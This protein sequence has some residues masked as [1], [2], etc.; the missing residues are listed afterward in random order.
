MPWKETDVMQE[1]IAFVVEA[2]GGT[3]SISALCRRYGISRKTGYKWLKRYREVKTLSE[4]SEASRRPHTS[5][6]KTPDW[7]EERVE[8]LR[9]LE[10]WG[11]RKI[12]RCLASEGVHLA[13]STVDRILERR[14]LIPSSSRHKPAVKRFEREAPNEMSQM[15]FK[16]WYP[17]RR[18]GQ[19]HPLS[20]LD[21]HSR[22]LQGL[23]ALPGQKTEPVKKCLISSWNLYGVPQSI[24]CDHGSP[25]WATSNGHGLTKL[26]VFLIR[27]GINILHG[28][29]G[30]PQ[31]QGKIER[32]HRTLDQSIRHRGAPRTL[33]EFQTAFDEFRER[34]NDLRPHEALGDDPP[35][36][37]YQPSL[38]AYE[39]NPREWEYPE[40]AK[41]LRVRDHG[42]VS[43]RSR[44]WFVCHALA[45]RR[46]R[47]DPFDSK[48]LVS[49]RHM[50]IREIDLETG[51]TTA[52]V[53]P[54]KWKYVLPMSPGQPVT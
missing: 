25:W 19:C 44:D 18:K 27:Q 31:T 24:L 49:Y 10:G 11:G 29:V 51:R 4:L 9:A 5:P 37:H 1:R 53:R 54:T 39:P 21:D 13:C 8:A 43:I 45:G 15:D 30:H 23:Y 48:I 32:F 33:E 20:I 26:S 16:G 47:I 28:A 36:R 50:Q 34:Y 14:G 2:A 35:S 6:H 17:L 42:C 22:F 38:K 7:I 40:G 3:E 46:V 12:A 41:V 52:V